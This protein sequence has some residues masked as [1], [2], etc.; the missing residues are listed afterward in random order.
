M[1]I[2]I[3]LFALF[4]IINQHYLKRDIKLDLERSGYLS[5]IYVK[6]IAIAPGRGWVLCDI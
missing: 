5:V 1:P 6:K 4:V 3:L 2:Y